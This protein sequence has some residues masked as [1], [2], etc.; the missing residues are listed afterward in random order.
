M[1]HSAGF[2]GWGSHKVLVVVAAVVL[3][4]LVAYP[5]FAITFAELHRYP[6]HMWT[7]I[8]SPYPW[9]R[10]A[11]VSYALLGLPVFVVVLVW[12]TS[13]TRAQLRAIADRTKAADDPRNR[14][15]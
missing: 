10:A 12:R 13:G 14:L 1:T 4:Y 7:G 15:A 5:A 8:G 9:R 3:A 2:A 6:R 11:V